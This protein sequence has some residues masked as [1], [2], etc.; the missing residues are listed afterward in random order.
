MTLRL[1]GVDGPVAELLLD[2]PDTLNALT[3]EDF[4]DGPGLLDQA[5]HSP[6]VRSLVVHGAGRAFC[7]GVDLRTLATLR[8]RGEQEREPLLRAGLHWVQSLV[9]FPR[10]T[11]AAVHGSCFGAGICVALAADRVVASADATFGLVFTR[12]GLP[13]GDTGALWLVSRRLGPRRAWQLFADATVLDAPAAHALGLVDE[14]AEPGKALDAA[15]SVA[16]Q[17]S[18]TAPTALAVSKEQVLRAEGAFEEF[19]RSAGAQIAQVNAAIGS[20]EFAEGLAA[21]REKRAPSY[22]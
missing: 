21:V 8:E 19:D 13:A 18:R 14:V 3:L 4:R 10:P 2:A 16:A 1:H 12:L 9:R 6:S 11:V 5:A 15:R 22:P 17:W 7:S 20:A